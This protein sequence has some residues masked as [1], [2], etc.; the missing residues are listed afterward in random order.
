[1]R[2]FFKQLLKSL[3]V[4]K[5]FEHEKY[6]LGFVRI[7]TIENEGTV[8]CVV[9]LLKDCSNSSKFQN[10]ILERKNSLQGN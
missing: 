7:D 6:I 10:Q 5:Y 9:F 4:R 1:M 8:N 2:I 3:F